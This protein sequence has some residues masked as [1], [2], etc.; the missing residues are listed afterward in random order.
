VSCSLAIAAGS[1]GP[2]AG[3][4]AVSLY[5]DPV[6]YGINDVLIPEDG[7]SFGARIYYPSEEMEVRDVPIRDG[8][9]PLIAFAHGDRS[10]E[11]GL[12]PPDRT[13]DYKKWGAVLHLLARC[14]FVVVSVAVHDVVNDSQ[15]AARRM[16][17]AIAWTRNSWTHRGVLFRPLQV[18]LDPD[19]LLSS[20]RWSE[21]DDDE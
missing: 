4:G 3:G 16:E 13:E 8:T 2:I 18:Y 6:Y 17:T 21:Q 11:V 10:G 15:T 5:Y 1:V 9:Y 20:E 19:V 12:C 7:G 14:G